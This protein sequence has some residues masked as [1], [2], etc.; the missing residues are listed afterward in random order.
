ME[1]EFMNI[2]IF[3]DSYIPIKNGVT[4]SVMQLKEG[5]EEKGHSV[6]IITV[7]VPNYEEKDI[8]IYR[9]PSIGASFGSG[10]DA[11]LSFLFNQRPIIRFLKKKKIELIHTHTEFT[12][13]HYGKMAAKKLKLPW[14]HTTH[15][16]W[17]E[18]RHYLLNGKVL[19]RGMVRKM[20]ASY[21]KEAYCLINPSIKA[22]NYYKELLPQNPSFVINNGIDVAKFKSSVITDNEIIRLR[23]TFG[24][25]KNDK[26]IIFVGR[27]GKE[28]RVVELFHLILPIL[29]ENNQVKMVFT[30]TGPQ[31]DQLMNKTKE[32]NL[33]KQIIFTGFVNWELVYRLY[34]LA[35]LFVT[36]SLSEVQPMTLIEATM[37]GLPI[38]TRRDESYFDLVI[39]DKNGF[40][41][42]SDEKMTERIN[43]LI[44][45]DEKL[46]EF[47]SYSLKISSKF[48]AENHVSKMEK[49]YTAVIKTYPNR[50]DP[51]CLEH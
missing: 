24:I 47:S 29:R 8:N 43:E 48:T 3:T 45:D 22:Q 51:S 32:I 6:I 39:D 12:I 30:G 15:T 33:G 17:E 38:I 35:N 2:A 18:Y 27:I 4:T 25:K 20:M 34:S 7:D 40:M 13:A 41:E 46:K 9:L 26:I 37:C 10:T 21:M 49:L 11:R 42:N 28:K 23:K 14:V 50:F 1:N 31:L 44:H 16:M 36:A 19:T 5:L